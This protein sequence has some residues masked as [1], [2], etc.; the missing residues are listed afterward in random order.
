MKEVCLKFVVAALLASSTVAVADDTHNL[1]AHPMPASA[2]VSPADDAVHLDATGQPVHMYE[3]WYWN[4]VLVGLG[5]TYGV[6]TIVFQFSFFPGFIVDVAQIAFTDVATGEF[7]NQL[8]WGGG[9]PFV[10][11][12]GYPFVP[13]GFNLAVSDS[14]GSF[15]GVGGGGHDQL[16]FKFEDGTIATLTYEGYKNPSASFFDGIGHY[17]DVVTGKTHGTQYYL[18]R[19]SMTAAGTIQRPGKKKEIVAGLGWYDRQWGTVIGTPGSQADNTYWKWFSLHLSDDTQ[20]MLWDMR[21]VDTGNQVIKVANRMSAAPSCRESTITDFTVTGL[22]STVFNA[23]PPASTLE[24]A[25]HISIPSE[26]LEI[27]VRMITPNQVIE[28]GGLFSPFL[29]GAATITGT[30]NGWP[31][32]GVGYYEQ[33]VPAGTV[34]GCCQGV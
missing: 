29:E 2:N 19:R 4:T 34:G 33:F 26:G 20:Y 25:N 15:K 5:K 22:G 31:I 1:C 16:E 12:S 30:K 9:A 28:T 24:N 13:N 23:G 6:E 8:V 3:Q 7:H 27:D 10:P 21:A 17:D 11:S 32:A 14:D 18:Q